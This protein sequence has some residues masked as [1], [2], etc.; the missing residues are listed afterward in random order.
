MN[1]EL[2]DFFWDTEGD[3]I[4]V[5]G[6]SFSIVAGMSESGR[7][8]DF[9]LLLNDKVVLSVDK[10]KF[11]ELSTVMRLLSGEQLRRTVEYA[12]DNGEVK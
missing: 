2:E 3:T 1:A 6:D 11:D 9:T 7:I 12:R 4:Y 10:Y 8:V 5:S